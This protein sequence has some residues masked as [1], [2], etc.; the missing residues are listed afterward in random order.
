MALAN[1]VVLVAAYLAVAAL[2]WGI[3][4]ASMAQ[5]RDLDRFDERPD[6][7][8]AWRIAHL[9]D[10]HVVGERY[11]F[12]LES[13]RSGPRGNE[14]LRRLLTELD[15]LHAREPLDVVV[16]GDMTDAGR[17]T[18][19]AE[20]MDAVMRHPRLAER[21]LIIPGNHD[22]NIVDRANPAR[23]DL[24]MSPNKRLRKLRV[25]A[26][27]AVLQGERVQV[28]SRAAPPG[29]K[30]RRDAGSHLREVA[31]FA[32]AGRPRVSR[33]LTELWTRVFPMV[34]P[35]ETDDGLGIILLDS[36]AD[37]HFSFTNALGMIS[38]DQARALDIACAQYPRACWVVVLHHHVVEYPRPAKIA[39]CA[40]R[41]RAGQRQLVRAPA[42]P[43]AGRA[44]LLHGHRHIDWIGNAA[45]FPSFFRAVAGHGGD[46]R[47]GHVLLHPHR[48]GG[49][50]PAPQIAAAATHHR[51][52]ESSPQA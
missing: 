6:G 4:D 52:G 42:K 9:S 16:S 31:A 24:P 40:R 29:R 7:G 13:G 37:T 1:S 39:V 44:V 30:P 41:H 43:L 33:S 12:R 26:A 25:L 22:L 21:M 50:R 28:G 5:P 46:R 51:G 34:L 10:V 27:M 32:D 49:R 36:N 17:S 20:F 15:A 45:A 3:A 2:V 47:H 35:P 23:F 38:A 19:W 11:G 18:E 8:R 48:G 14:R